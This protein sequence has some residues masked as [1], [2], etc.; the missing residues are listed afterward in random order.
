LQAVAAFVAEVLC[1][2]IGVPL[3]QLE[4]ATRFTEDLGMDEL[5][6]VEFVMA[7]E[8]DLEFSIPDEDCARLG[9]VAVLVW[10][11]HERIAGRERGR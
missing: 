9:T 2:Q 6:P 1:E 10:Y 3:S 5:E 11:L 7:L 4:P 8:D